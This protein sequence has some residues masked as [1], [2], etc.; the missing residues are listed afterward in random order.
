MEMVRPSLYPAPLN[1]LSEGTKTRR[2]AFRF[3]THYF[4][5]Y[6]RLDGSSQAPR[7]DAR[8]PHGT[9]SFPPSFSGVVVFYHWFS[10]SP[11]AA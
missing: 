2:R 5:N 4:F 11:Y 6:P 1:P 7:P 10:Q 8:R 3:L 9:P